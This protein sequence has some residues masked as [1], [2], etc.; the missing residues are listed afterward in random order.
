MDVCLL[1]CGSEILAPVLAQGAD[2]VGGQ[3][4]VAGLKV[5]ADIADIALL[6]GLCVGDN[7]LEIVLAVLAQRADKVIGHVRALVDVAADLADPALLL[8]GRGV[9]LGLDVRVIVAVGTGR[10]VGED[11]RLHDVG[12]KEHL[13]FELAGLHDFAGE[14]GVGVLRD[15]AHAVSRALAVG[16]IRELVH[17]A[18]ALEAEALE[19]AVGRILGEDG[20]VEAIGMSQV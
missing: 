14:D 3:L 19:Q 15:V 10:A 2:V 8:L 13:V 7:V 18:A 11:L 12:D 16:H 17:V 9:L 5:A 20:D 6:L 1:L 4:T